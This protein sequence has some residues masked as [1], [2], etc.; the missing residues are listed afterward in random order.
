MY[1]DPILLI[2]P[3][4]LPLEAVFPFCLHCYTSSPGRHHFL[5]RPLQ[6]APKCLRV[7]TLFPLQTMLCIY[8]YHSS[9]LKTYMQSFLPLKRKTLSKYLKIKVQK[10][11]IICPPHI[12]AP[13]QS[14]PSFR[15]H[16]SLYFIKYDLLWKHHLSIFYLLLL[17]LGLIVLFPRILFLREKCMLMSTVHTYFLNLTTQITWLDRSGG[18]KE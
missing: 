13:L 17:N 16:C 2:L 11:S 18:E 12:A 10:V 6:M 1:N 8:C 3:L 9:I 14:Q 4:K 5:P 7:S 15:Y